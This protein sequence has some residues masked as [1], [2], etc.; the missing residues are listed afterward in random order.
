[1]LND[2]KDTTRNIAGTVK[3]GVFWALGWL[4][5][6]ILVII[7]A[8][9]V[10]IG[11]LEWVGV[12]TGVPDATVGYFIHWT[13]GILIGVIPSKLLHD[14]LVSRYTVPLRDVKAES[15]DAA[16]WKLPME[17]WEN[18]TVYEEH[19]ID[20]ETIVTEAEKSDL[21]QINTKFGPGYECKNYDPETNT[22]YV[23]WMAGKNATD[24][25]ADK[26]NIS[27]ILRELTTVADLALDVVS[28]V[29]QIARNASA[30][31]INK[32]IRV[33]EGVQLQDPDS[34]TSSIESA[35]ENSELAN[36]PQINLSNDSDRSELDMPTPASE[37][38]KDDDEQ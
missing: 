9:T 17:V 20:G 27:Y 10:L 36:H 21:W 24:I 31:E 25:R 34:V 16:S 1:M 13:F 2:A 35:I 32:N 33:T 4:K 29:R 14:A 26:K 3:N 22:A 30:R 38:E 23:T 8:L 19:E 15:G 28:N 5:A 37:K 6:Y 7:V 12:S 11:L 18:L